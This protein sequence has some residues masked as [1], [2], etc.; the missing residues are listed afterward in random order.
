[1]QGSTADMPNSSEIKSG[2]FDDLFMNGVA[3]INPSDIESITI[4]KD[5]SATAIYGSRAAGGVIV[6]TTKKENKEKPEL[7]ILVMFPLL[8]LPNEIIL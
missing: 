5:A 4:L 7:T 2:Q 6:V 1:M 3:G 8:C